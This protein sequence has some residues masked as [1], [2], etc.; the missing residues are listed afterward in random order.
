MQSTLVSKAK[1]VII[2]LE[3]AY[4]IWSLLFC[5]VKHEVF[6][7][8]QMNI[9]NKDYSLIMNYSLEKALKNVQSEYNL[10]EGQIDKIKSLF[11]EYSCCIKPWIPYHQLIQQLNNAQYEVKFRSA[12]LKETIE[13]VF[14]DVHDK[15]EV[16][17]DENILDEDLL[18]SSDYTK[19]NDRANTILLDGRVLDKQTS[20]VKSLYEVDFSKY[21]P[22]LSSLTFKK[23]D[24]YFV[25]KHLVDDLA[26]YH[27]HPILGEGWHR[28]VKIDNV[29]LN[30]KIVKG[31]QRGSKQLGCPTA[32]IEMTPINKRITADLIPG[33]YAAYATFVEPKPELKIDISKSPF[34]CALSIGWNPVYENL[35]QTVEAYIIHDFQGQDFYGEELEVNLVSFIRPEAL[36]PT[37]DD[38]ILAIACDIRST[39][40]YLDKQL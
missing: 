10:Q 18:I 12:Y 16:V 38:L 11:L 4:D 21:D 29:W 35:E 5:I 13:Q 6:N 33:V 32:N 2:D 23:P 30:G 9:K 25:S 8:K 39:E 14:P 1:R 27:T 3:Q 20:T 7:S 24:A 15:I 26:E 34:K 28:H 36:Y 22:A 37:F 17:N 19:Y 31:F 40:Q